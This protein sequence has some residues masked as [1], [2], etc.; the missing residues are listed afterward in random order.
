V[1]IHP[2]QLAA[3]DSKGKFDSTSDSPG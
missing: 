3:M 2:P 1:F